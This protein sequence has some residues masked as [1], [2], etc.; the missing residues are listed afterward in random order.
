MK[1]FSCLL[2]ILV[3]LT[4]C[5]NV[6]MN[7]NFACGTGKGL[8]CKSVSEVNDIVESS[9]ITDSE[10]IL[11]SDEKKGA[12]VSMLK[13]YDGASSPDNMPK[14]EPEKRIKIWF[15]PHIDAY[16]NYIEETVVYAVIK[17]AHWVN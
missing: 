5:S 14:R 7:S 12:V 1:Q 10:I 8:G 15:A 16:D 2:V 11:S 13:Y 4:G 3:F 9:Q 6:A 17:D